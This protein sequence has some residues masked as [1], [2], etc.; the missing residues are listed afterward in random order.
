MSE[1][2]N[3]VLSPEQVEKQIK[4]GMKKGHKSHSFNEKHDNIKV[5]Q[6][7]FQRSRHGRVL[8]VVFYTQACQWGQC[9]GCN[10]M[11]MCSL[12]HIGFRDIMMQVDN[13]FGLPE[14]QNVKDEI[15]QI[16]VSNNGSVLDQSTFSTTALVYLLSQ[17]NIH[18]QNLEVLTMETRANYVDDVELEM[19]NRTIHEGATPT[20]FELAIGVEAFDDAIRN[21]HFQKGLKLDTFTDLVRRAAKFNVLLKTYFMQKPVPGMSDD[22]AILDIRNGI[23]FLHDI[24]AS[25]GVDINMHLN[26][27]Y[28]SGGTVLEEHFRKGDFTPPFLKDVA[29]AVTYAEG[30]LISV[31]VGLNDEGL[32]VEEGS[33]IRQGDG[34]IVKALDHF[35]QTGDFTFLDSFV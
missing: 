15:R 30:T 22:E 6:W 23:E 20:R 35:N 10:L 9:L 32:A 34:P 26:P 19:I 12:H 28:V 25:Y 31:Y 21:D 13:L 11:S 29:R 2:K 1:Q 18:F 14:I 5:A 24:S 3:I 7:W 16:I 27:T 8:F 17:V 33:F 4:R